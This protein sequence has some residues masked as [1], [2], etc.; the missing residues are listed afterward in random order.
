MRQF[1]SGFLMATALALASA[2]GVLA[3]PSA[4]ADCIAEAATSF[5]PGS[6]GPALSAQARGVGLGWFVGGDGSGLAPTDP[7]DCG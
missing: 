7:P 2:S 3:A 6:L 5:A 4:E 1:M